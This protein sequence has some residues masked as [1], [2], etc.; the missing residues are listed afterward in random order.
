MQDPFIFN[1]ESMYDNDGMKEDLVQIKH[2]RKIKMEFHSMQLDTVWCTQ[3]NTFP[4]IAKTATKVLVSLATTYLCEGGSST[5]LHIKTKAKNRLEQ[6]F[7][8]F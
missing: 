1:L 8:T 7:S 5:L 6:W 2:S 3:P 4:H